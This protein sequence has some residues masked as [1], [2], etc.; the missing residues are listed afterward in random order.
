MCVAL[1]VYKHNSTMSKNQEDNV[2]QTNIDRLP[3][4]AARYQ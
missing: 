1:W 3:I 4:Q 2:T